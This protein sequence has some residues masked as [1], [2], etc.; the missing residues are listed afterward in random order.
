MPC[1]HS[2]NARTSPPARPR[3]AAADGCPLA[4]KATMS[5]STY[6]PETVARGADALLREHP[7][8]LVAG[9]ASTATARPVRSRSGS[10][11]RG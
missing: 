5:N 7:D 1:T 2:T 4:L 3:S 11:A 6:D 9:L 10:G 8:A